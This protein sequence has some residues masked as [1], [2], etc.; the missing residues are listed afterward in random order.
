MTAVAC[1]LLMKRGSNVCNEIIAHGAVLL[2]KKKPVSRLRKERNDISV[3]CGLV[4]INLMSI[5]KRHG[6]WH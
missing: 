3:L 6:H 1:K 4:V 5:L 2:A